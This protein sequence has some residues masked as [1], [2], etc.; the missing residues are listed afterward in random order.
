MKKRYG[1]LGM[2]MVVLAAAG[3]YA[4]QHRFAIQATY[5]QHTLPPPVAYE[6]S[7]PPVIE[8]T[9]PKQ[10]EDAQETA[11][12]IDVPSPSSVPEVDAEESLPASVNLAVP[13]TSQAPKGDWNL[14][15]QEA[16]E[17]ASLLMVHAYYEGKTG[18]LPSNMAEQDILDIVA[19]EEGFLG[20]YLDTTTA[21]TALLAEQYYGFEQIDVVEYPTK[22]MIQAVV[23]SGR[24][25][26]VPAAGRALENPFFTPPGPL[27]HMLVIRGYTEKGF[28]TNDPGTRRGEA[29]VYAY[30]RLLSAMHDWNDGDVEAGIPMML[31]ITPNTKTHE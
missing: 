6:A 2:L 9:I 17:E 27:Y 13:F 8:E 16:C 23:A 19:F 30:D 24:P 21:Q 11:E 25:V 1:V 26:I 22:E 31:V 12:V 10:E 14:P 3:F 4:W 28:I 29:Y 18:V 20:T 5:I 15:F 7:R